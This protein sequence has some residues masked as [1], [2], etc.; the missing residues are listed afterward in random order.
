MNNNK[1]KTID[2][3]NFLKNMAYVAA[4]TI[5]TFVCLVSC[6]EQGTQLENEYRT[7]CAELVKGLNE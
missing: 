3:K 4:I 6:L 1:K 5:A 2:M 7:E